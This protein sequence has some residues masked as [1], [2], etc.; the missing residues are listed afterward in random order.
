MKP[1]LKYPGSKWNLASWIIDHMPPHES[2]L[3][4]FFGS[5]AVL[6]NKE[7]SRIE[8]INDRDGEIVNFFRVCRDKPE[9][10]ARAINLT[11]WARDELA[12]CREETAY[13]VERARRTAV[14]CHM[15]FGSRRCGKSFK[16]ATGKNKDGGPDHAKLWAGVPKIVLEAAERLKYVQVENKP[17]LELIRGF[18]GPEVFIY[19]D[20][21]YVKST[22]T[23]HGDQYNFEMTEKDHEELLKALVNSRAKIILSGYDNTLYNDY[24]TGWKKESIKARVER[25]GTKTE[26]IWYNYAQYEQIAIFDL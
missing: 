5:G 20:P 9:E 25:G 19:L 22:R 26:T 6:F 11:P 10:L 16:H 21:P 24:L 1:V 12:A 3:E 8:T 17:A 13:P 23:L 14:T 4:P 2:Y 18:D 7:P 15:T